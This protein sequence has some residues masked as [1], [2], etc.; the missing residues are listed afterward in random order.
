VYSEVGHGT[1]FKVYLPV[2]ELEKKSRLVARVGVLAKGSE[3]LLLVEDSDPMRALSRSLLE[4]AGYSVIEA[5][6][7]AEALEI[8]R[9]DPGTISLMITDVV[10]P[11]MSG[12]QLAEQIAPLRPEM[13]VLYVSGYTDDAVVNHGVLESGMAFLQKPFTREALTR[14]VRELLDRKLAHHAQ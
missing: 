7:P 9:S 5:P 6:T 11:G 8:I 4:S 10:M 14:K 2:V 3:T 12:R 13:Q 1:T